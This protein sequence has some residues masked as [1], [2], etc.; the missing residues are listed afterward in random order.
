MLKNYIKTAFRNFRRN[1]FYTSLNITG[2]AIGI[3]TCMLILLYVHDELSY[4]RFNA[5]ASRIYRINNE[6][7]FG[8]N[9]FD[10]AQTPA[11]LGTEAV[12]QLPQ[13][14]QYTRLR[15]RAPL[16]IKKGAANIRETRLAYSDSTLF[17]V[18]T[19]PMI[20]GDPLTALKE[21][22]SLVITESMARKYFDHTDVAGQYLTIN[23]TVRY[24]VTGVIRDIPQNSHF[25]FDLILPFVEMKESRSDNWLSQNFNTYLVLK[26]GTD[27][28]KV[29]QQVDALLQ[30]F[31]EPE[32]RS[33][34]GISLDEFNKQGS[35][36]KCTLTP[37]TDIHL[38][39]N[40]EGEMAPNGDIQYVYIF[41]LVAFFILA[42]A[43]V[44][45]MNLFTARA[46]NRARE[47]GVRK[48]LGSLRSNLIHQF[49][50]E[51]L[52]ISFIALLVA[53]LMVWPI[54][55]YFNELAGKEISFYVLLKPSM[56]G[57]LLLFALMIGLLAGTYPAFLLSSFQPIEV[58]KGKLAKGFKGSWLRNA[59]V[60][61]QFAVS[62]MLIIGTIVIYGQLRYMHR[63]DIG[64][65][66]QQVLVIHNTDAL[67]KELT[68]FKNG[69]QQLSG[70]AGVTM[71][72]YLPVSGDRNNNAFFTSPALDPKSVISMQSWYVD[73]QYIPT[74]A[75]KLLEGRNF[76]PQFP[77]D[78]TGIILNEAAAARFLATNTALN[79]KLYVLADTKSKALKEYHVIGVMK[80]FHFNSLRES[81][82]P[83]ALFLG[84]DRTSIAVRLNEQHITA[85][86]GAIQRQW[87][88]M[89]PGQPFVHSFMNEEFDRLYKTDQRTG[90]ITVSFAIL[91]ILI[92]C[93][94][95]FALVAYA[96][97]QRIKEIGIR[98]VLGASVISLLRLLSFNFLKLVAIAA[99]ISFPVSW[100]AMNKWLQGFAY[101]IAISWQ[102]FAI[103]GVAAL[104]IAL[105]TI[106][107]QAIKAAIANPV[108]SL[109]SE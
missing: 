77:T 65:N 33:V 44:N 47:I 30:S 81:I 32:L 21:P 42:I 78:S 6:I 15:W 24:K 61:F 107:F 19:L 16:L 12:K 72:G 38:H 75:V 71:T 8:G 59:L 103:A 64:F 26:K 105:L 40:R 74:L 80:N 4:D 20:S 14:E 68:A 5:K 35:F 92:A 46:S 79:K 108:E 53:L 9:Y 91:A 76:S 7:R 96:A 49:L 84:K 34:L 10:V 18:F 55:P 45:F 98:K 31:M 67:K 73:D 87:R 2:L 3:A 54:L 90:K 29:S 60:V 27:V 50:I 36:V 51:S 86:I 63:K 70:V 11:L 82:T 23:D 95:L 43:C 97:E 62:I 88:S 102:V 106:S 93:L 85:T 58:L 25:N 101:R 13:V 104:L 41:S 89:A 28:H 37:L 56:A 57:A 69:L 48:V 100:W 94:G 83:L 109:R 66:R 17:E 22:H 52:L 99:L 39:S 1:K